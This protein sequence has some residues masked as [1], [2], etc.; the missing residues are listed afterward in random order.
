MGCGCGCGGSNKSAIKEAIRTGVRKALHEQDDLGDVDAEEGKMHDLLGVP[1]DQ[2]I[3][4]EY[5]SGEELARDLVDATEDEQEASGMIAYAA[6][7]DPEDNVFDDA[8]EAIGEIDFEESSNVRSAVRQAIREILTEDGDDYQ[9]FV[10]SVMDMLNIDDPQDLT[11]EGREQFFTFV[12]EK[13][14]A[15]TDQADEVSR[16]ELADE[17]SA[18]HYSSESKVPDFLKKKDE[19]RRKARKAVKKIMSEV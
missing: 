16:G 7:I 6:N 2:N 12:D 4:D 18:D 14:N 17:F 9:E 13:Y 1:E 19:I 11:D 8:L 15:N 10:N 3:S 5:D